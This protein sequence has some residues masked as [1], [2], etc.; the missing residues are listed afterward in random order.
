V[1]GGYGNIYEESIV[2][3]DFALAFFEIEGRSEAGCFL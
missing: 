2:G 3:F 1:A